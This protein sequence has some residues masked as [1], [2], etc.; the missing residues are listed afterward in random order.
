MNKTLIN[1][2]W[3]S[4]DTRLGPYTIQVGQ[5]VTNEQ[6]HNAYKLKAWC[7]SQG[8]S[9]SATCGMIG[10]AIHESTL[11]PAFIQQTNRN[12][13]P[14]SAASLS[15][16]PNNVMINFYKEYYNDPNRNYGIGI[17]Q[18][19]GYTPTPPAGQ[20]LVSFCERYGLNWYDGDSQTRRLKAE[21]DNDL[22]FQ[23]LEV[24]G[25][26]WTW[27]NYVINTR[28]PEESADIWMNNYESPG[29]GLSER[30]GNARWFYDWFT[31]HPTPPF[32]IPNWML[33]KFKRKKELRNAKWKS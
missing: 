20:K 2:W 28:T 10:N 18:W 30:E 25:I 16:V 27:Y 6:M 5:P 32:M 23:H 26:V 12:R 21:Y 3:M 13:L 33:F 15:D 4:T 22:Q 8:W 24:F 1:G 9:L 31:I 29:G 14:N 7:D 17:V 11:S 19:D